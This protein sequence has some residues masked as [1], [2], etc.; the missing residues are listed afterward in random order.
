MFKRNV[1]ANYL[2]HGW[3]VAINL[4]FVPLQ[5]KLLGIESYALVGFFALLQNWLYVLDC[6]VTPTLNREMSRFL[7]GGHTV[8]QIRT[9]FKTSERILIVSALLTVA[10]VY[11]SV[12]LITNYWLSSDELPSETISS[13]IQLMGLVIGF[14][15]LEGLYRGC[16][17]GLQKQVTL[18]G[19][20]SLSSTLRSAGAVLVLMLVERSIEVFFLWQVA[21]SV[22]V[23]LVLRW[24]TQRA[25]PKSVEPTR[26]RF[27]SVLQLSSFAGGMLLSTLLTLLISNLD[28]ALLS[29]FLSL[30][31][32]GF[33]TF[34]SIVGGAIG[35]LGA[36]INQS[37]LPKL[38]ELCQ[39][40]DDASSRIYF[41]KRLNML[42]CA[43]RPWR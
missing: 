41:I 1:I 13:S 42:L 38:C 34:A 10:I 43:S 36:P 26:F 25:I 21:V 23:V 9:I 6:G 4:A 15:F 3:N 29:H 18:N 30:E 20:V 12:P 39:R 8:H 22:L 40:G 16:L 2:G 33:Y 14:R 24:L 32:F 7:G 28:K 19:V 37:V 11:V 17:S 27:Q 5:V 35:V 31:E